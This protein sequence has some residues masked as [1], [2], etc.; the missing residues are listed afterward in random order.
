MPTAGLVGKA[1][2]ILGT[3][4]TGATS[5]TFNGTPATTFTLVSSAL[6]TTTVPAGATSGAVQVTTPTATLNSNVNVVVT[7]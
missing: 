1:V 5:V 6:I 4:L 7:P 3:G 2:N